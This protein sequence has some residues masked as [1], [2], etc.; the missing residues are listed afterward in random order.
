[1]F[2][3]SENPYAVSDK[4]LA[5]MLEERPVA[6]HNMFALK[7]EFQAEIES[8]LSEW[9][10][11]KESTSVELREAGMSVQHA[12]EAFAV[13]FALRDRE[14]H[15]DGK[16]VSDWATEQKEKGRAVFVRGNPLPPMREN[17]E[18]YATAYLEIAKD[19]QQPGWILYEP[20]DGW[21]NIAELT[22]SSSVE[23]AIRNNPWVV[24]AGIGVL[25]AASVVLYY[26]MSRRKS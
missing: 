13:I 9:V 11:A 7:P 2:G 21:K 25:G 14:H 16:R 24:L 1:M 26:A 20:P 6:G 17:L 12:L 18:V 19:V 5:G 23:L 8:R 15:L 3:L 4:L 10:V 22:E